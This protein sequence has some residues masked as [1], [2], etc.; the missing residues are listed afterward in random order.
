[1]GHAKDKG[2]SAS[3]HIS[4]KA[5]TEYCAQVI[6]GTALEPNLFADYVKKHGELELDN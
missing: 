5:C 3:S 4:L 2:E 6:E 1:V